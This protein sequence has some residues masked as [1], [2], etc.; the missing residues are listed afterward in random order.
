MEVAAWFGNG[1]RQVASQDLLS[2][3]V[4]PV[5]DHEL[6]QLLQDFFSP[7]DGLTEREAIWPVPRRPI[8]LYICQLLQPVGILLIAVLHEFPAYGP[9]EQQLTGQPR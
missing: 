8:G 7:L 6:H 9:M 3:P 2:T 5:T 1:L 4:I